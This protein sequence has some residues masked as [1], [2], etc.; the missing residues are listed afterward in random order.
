MTQKSKTFV[1]GGLGG[2]RSPTLGGLGGGGVILIPPPLTTIVSTIVPK[3]LIKQCPKRK[4]H[5]FTVNNY[6]EELIGGFLS[7]FDI[8]ATRYAFQEEICP[9]TKTPHLQGMVMF[10]EEKRSTIWDPT[11]KGHWETLKKTD[12]VYQLKE[13]SRKPNGR[14][15]VKGLPKPLK[16]ITPSKPW[17]LDILEL[18]KTEPDDRKIYWFWSEAGSIGKSQFAKYC[19]HTINCLFFEEGK[20][21]DIMHLIF[22]APEER[23]GAMIV[24]VP[25]DNGNNVSYKALESIKNGMIYS[26]KYEGGYKLFNSPHVIVFANLPPQTQKMSSDRWVIQ[27]IDEPIA[28]ELNEEEWNELEL[29]D[30]E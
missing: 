28:V 8:H 26:S 29:N 30:Y 5:F 14:Q 2:Q 15:W 19:V 11:S 17:Q 9:T 1:L 10:S 13:A 22:E 20:K 7:Y 3:P 12:A 21:S 25:R 6:T 24:D 16:L 4:N 27:N 23:M 18:L